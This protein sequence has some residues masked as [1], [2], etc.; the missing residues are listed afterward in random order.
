MNKIWFFVF[1]FS[2]SSRFNI[3]AQPSNKQLDSLITCWNRGT[4]DS[5]K[6][7]ILNERDSLKVNEYKNRLDGFTNRYVVKNDTIAS[8]SSDRHLFLTK[9]APLIKNSK[10]FYIIETFV[11]SAT[12][13]FLN[14]LVFRGKDRKI[15]CIQYRYSNRGWI[16]MSNS[17]R[18]YLS[19]DL[20]IGKAIDFNDK[21]YNY[22]D[23]IISKFS[24]M[25]CSESIYYVY[26][27]L[28]YFLKLTLNR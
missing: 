22:E 9:I 19:V 24:K 23:V 18:K 16:E 5:F 17:T 4:I 8:G 13:V 26:N 2:C 3:C 14:T 15:I 25:K 20:I 6:A 28:S 1:I 11:N 12:M 21:P 27:S 10:D 7:Y